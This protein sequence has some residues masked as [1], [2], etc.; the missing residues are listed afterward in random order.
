MARLAIALPDTSLTDMPER[1]R[2]DERAHDDVA[3][4]LRLARVDVVEVQR[5]VVHRDQAE[6]VVVRLGHGLGGPVL[7]HGAD[8]ELLQIA[9]VGVGPGGLA[10]GL[11]GLDSIV[12][13]R[14]I[15][16]GMPTY[17]ARRGE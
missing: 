6:E 9:P 11:I 13:S 16:R 14:L 2:V 10:L 17:R 15:G 4:L 12:E 8:L 7:V 3:A 1:Q 5:V